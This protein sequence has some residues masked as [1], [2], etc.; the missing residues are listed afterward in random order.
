MLLDEVSFFQ[1]PPERKQCTFLILANTAKTLVHPN[2]AMNEYILF[3][4]FRDKV[5]VYCFAEKSP[6]EKKGEYLYF[7]CSSFYHSIT[8]LAS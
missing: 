4:Y 2:T 5:P 8:P 3:V 6:T 7:S 1:F